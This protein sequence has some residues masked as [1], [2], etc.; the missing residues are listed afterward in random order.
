MPSVAYIAQVRV[1]PDC[2]ALPEPLGIHGILLRRVPRLR[3]AA[4][5]PQLVFAVPPL[6][7]RHEVPQRE[8]GLA[9]LLDLERDLETPLHLPDDPKPFSP[10]SDGVSSSTT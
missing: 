3:E 8:D 2:R 7:G 9:A 1:V 10:R 6:Q 5:D 4:V